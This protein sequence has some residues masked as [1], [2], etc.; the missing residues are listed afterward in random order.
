[1]ELACSV[2][3]PARGILSDLG[4]TE[5]YDFRHLV[6][7]LTR[8]FEP[9]NQAAVH[10]AELHNRVRKE[11]EKLT[12][13][14]QD[15]KRLVRKAYPEATTDMKVALAKDC[16]LDS[17]DDAELAWAIAQGQPGILEEAVQLGLQYEAFH[18]GLSQRGGFSEWVCD[19][20]LEAELDT[21]QDNPQ[22]DSSKLDEVL[23]R[24]T[25]L[26]ALLAQA[27]RKPK[28]RN[29][30]DKSEAICFFCQGKG[31]FKREC[32]ERARKQSE[33]QE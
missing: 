14:A 29:R 20:S 6:T 15:I 8:R 12:E 9:D 4:A 13:L 30:P 32:P 25:K 3:G 10:R 17:L 24:L 1:M 27:K 7:A 22:N 18:C 33:G 31:H 26:E 16:F 19:N 23:R 5:R 11:S 2:R 28:R 21:E